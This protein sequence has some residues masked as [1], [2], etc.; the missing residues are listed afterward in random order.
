MKK[1][2]AAL[3][4]VI[5]LFLITP[6]AAIA[7]VPVTCMSKSALMGM[8][9]TN[10]AHWGLTGTECIPRATGQTDSQAWQ[11]WVDTYI[12][13]RTNVT[14]AEGFAPGVSSRVV[15]STG[16]TAV[17][18][19]A[20]GEVD[21]PGAFGAATA[22]GSKVLMTVNGW[23][24]WNWNSPAEGA[25]DPVTG[26]V[27]P[28]PP[29]T[30]VQG[31]GAGAPMTG[32]GIY[33]T[34]PTA[35]VT[36]TYCTTMTGLTRTLATNPVPTLGAFAT[37]NGLLLWQ[38]PTNTKSAAEVA[39]NWIDYRAGVCT[40]V[41]TCLGGGGNFAGS[42][43]SMNAAFNT[44]TKVLSF[45]PV[46]SA[47]K[48]NTTDTA[49]LPTGVGWKPRFYV[50][51]FGT[52]PIYTFVVDLQPLTATPST[53]RTIEQTLTCKDIS[54][55]ITTVTG[56]TAYTP[57]FNVA[58]A[59]LNCAA[60]SIAVDIDGEIKQANS[61]GTNHTPLTTPCLGGNC[62]TDPDAK[63]PFGDVVG[64]EPDWPFDPSPEPEVT[65]ECKKTTVCTPDEVVFTPLAPG[66]TKPPPDPDS[67]DTLNASDFCGWSWSDVLNPVEAAFK[68]FSCALKW[69]FVPD[70]GF[71]TETMAQA[72]DAFTASGVGVMTTGAK[73]LVDD[74]IEKFDD[75]GISDCEG[76]AIVFDVD[77]HPFEL[78]V[79]DL[80]DA[81]IAGLA[82]TFHTLMTFLVSFSGVIAL[83][84]VLLRSLGLPALFSGGGE[85]DGD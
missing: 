25:A 8:S 54:G 37:G 10:K 30:W 67:P 66:E 57:A 79:F 38:S 24:P 71:M 1:L 5:V 44:T 40:P 81:P 15:V 53:T 61:A 45:S 3:A 28:F 35:C 47:L 7:T 78:H 49:G 77:G 14:V 26:I 62:L 75:F 33:T 13:D 83:V 82:A 60:G 18:A 51:S 12:A 27:N 31:Y 16:A 41:N 64:T 84:N 29:G 46:A 11:S 80:C 48:L 42:V 50:G 43:G 4:A 69:A 21:L 65:V 20:M 59:G 74:T 22:A 2:L 32:N 72:S 85:S 39:Q 58:V 56:S 34:T 36:A 63:T 52:A 70:E 55:A 23:A 6:T 9:A 68:G 76:P 73:T 19:V 17:R